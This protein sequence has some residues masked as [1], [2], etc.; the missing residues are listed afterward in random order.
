MGSAAIGLA[1]F[2]SPLFAFPGWRAAKHEEARDSVGG[3]GAAPVPSRFR[4]LPG[5]R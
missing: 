2:V 5:G 3:A 1:S 4:R